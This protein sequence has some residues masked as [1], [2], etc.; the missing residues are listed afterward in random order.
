[1]LERKDCRPFRCD[2]SITTTCTVKIKHKT[3][4]SSPT[5]LIVMWWWAYAKMRWEVLAWF[6]VVKLV[7]QQRTVSIRKEEMETCGEILNAASGA[8]Q[9]QQKN[10]KMAINLCKNKDKIWANHS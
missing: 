7:L 2:S 5:N 6:V 9:R 4:V 3:A 8:L 1:M 10:I